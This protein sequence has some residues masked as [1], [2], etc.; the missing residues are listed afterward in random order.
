[1]TEHVQVGG[2]Q[3]AK[4]LF[5]F[6]NNEA[7]P[8]TGITADQFWAGADKVIHDLAPKNK[9]LLA[10]RDDFQARIDTWHQTHAGQAHDPVAYKA[11]LQDIGYLLP[12]AADFQASTQ[13]V[14]DEIA[15]MAGP[16]LVVPVMNAR[17]ALNASNARWGSLYDALYGTD[18]ISE[19]DGAEKGKGYNKVRGDKVI[20]FARAFLDEA[21][22][23]SAGSHV[24]STGYK[25]VDGKLIVSLKGGSNSGLRDD[26]QLIGFQGDSAQPIAILLKHNGLHFEIQIDASTPVG[27]TDAAGVKDV[28]MEAAL[29]TIMDCEDSV[30][31]VDADDKVVIYRNWLG[32]MKGDLAEEVAKGGKT[33]T[34]TMNPDRV[35]TGV[36]GQDVTLHGRSLLFVRNVG[37][38]MT[39]DAILDKDGNEVPEGILD[40]LITSL[41]AIHSLNG[42]TSRKNS[43]TG[44]VYIVKP[45]MHGPEEAAFTNELFGRVEDVLNLPRNTL[46]VGIMDEERRTTVNL[47]ACIKAASER[48]VFINTGFLDRTGDEIHTSMEAGAMVRKAAM[49]SEKWIAA[50]ENWNVDIGLSTGLQGRAQIGKGMWAMP[51]LMAAMLE[52]KIAHPLAGAN[53]AWV[54]S[55]TAAAL[56][57]LHYHKVDVFARQAEL[58]KRERAS[59]DDIL[60]IPLA[61]NTDWSEEEIRNELDNNAQGILGYVVRWIDQGVGCSKVPDINDVGL[62]EDRA[63]LRI[64]SQHIANWLRHGIVNQAQVMESLKRMAPVVDRQNAGDALYR[65]LAPDF[66]SNIAFQA[67]V[68]LVIEGTKQPNGYTEPVLHRR[69]REFKAKNGL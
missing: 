23:L 18:A 34:R 46:K 37:H 47:K 13:N 26:S 5:D 57:A 44:S 49:K 64:S 40:G 29:T 8:G 27:Q 17:F 1:M 65:P 54:P 55:P 63:T 2:L 48:V 16:Q 38:L 58:A 67:A 32:L 21:A 39:I 14:D 52:Q 28:L 30:A 20:A 3:V 15:R 31:A 25:I 43:R 66:D 60:T 22:P 50:Y 41:A 42:N 10:K 45:K 56:H 36:N 19:A 51:D 33:F 53:T 62:M 7:I 24:D 69:R 68:E 11:F 4:V 35:Y 61:T 9:A 59:V 6:V 12:E